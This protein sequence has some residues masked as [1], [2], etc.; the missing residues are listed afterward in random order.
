MIE[1]AVGI[2][3]EAVG[4]FADDWIANGSSHSAPIV[5][6]LLRAGLIR[7]IPEPLETIFENIE[8][9]EGLVHL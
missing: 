8:F 2:P 6:G 1:Y 5:H 7:I 3:F 4:K 9:G